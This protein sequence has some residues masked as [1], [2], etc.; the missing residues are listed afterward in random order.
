MRKDCKKG[1]GG[2]LAYI[3]ADILV[4]RRAKLEPADFKTICLDINVN[5]S[6]FIVCACYRSPGKCK[7]VDFLD[8]LSS[9]VEVTYNTRKELLLLGDFN[10]DMY[11]NSEEGRFPNRKLADCCQRFCLVNKITEQTRVT[12][13]TMTLID[14]ALSSH[15]ERYATA[16]TLH[17]G[18][19][20]HDLVGR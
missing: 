7:E 5:R 3:R 14:V 15:P 18:V 12:D 4:Y 8:T 17:L 13:K 1:A 19:S 2:L 10:M 20:D 9:A 16:G 6:R 11:H